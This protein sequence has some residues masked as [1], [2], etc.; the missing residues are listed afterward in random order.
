MSEA[1]A[2]KGPD[3][4][5]GVALSS[6]VDGVPLAGHVGD[7]PVLLLR[8]GD[9]V[10]A[11]GGSCTHYGGPLDEGLVVRGEE[12]RC[13]WHHACFS[14]R[15]G[16]VL[17]AP[18]LSPLARW[19]PETTGGVV[20][21]KERAP[22]GAAAPPGPSAEHPGS[23]VIIGAGA[24]GSAAAE[25]LRKEGYGG[26]VVLID[27][28][29][30]A[31]YDRPNLSKDYLAGSA[32]EEWL[33]LRPPGFFAE[34]EIERVFATAAAIDAE[35]RRV[36]LGDGREV[37]YG[38]LLLATGASPIMLPLPGATLPHVHVLRS[39]DDCRRLIAGVATARQAVIAGASFIG[40]EAAAALRARGVEVTVVA[41]EAVPFARTL[42]EQL[43]GMLQG[44]HEAAGV[45]FRLGRTVS[46]IGPRE[47]TID[48]GSV[49]PADLVLLGVGVRPRLELAASAGVAGARGVP[50]NEYLETSA[51]GIW[52]A[53]DI[54][55]YPEP[56]TGAA[57]RVE[58]WVAAQRQGQAAARNILGA[59]APFRVVP[60][61]WT[62]QYGV[63]VNYVGHAREWDQVEIEGD[64]AAGDCRVTYLAGGAMLAV[65]T[66]GRD[67]E[68]LQA[69]LEMESA[70]APHTNH[71]RGHLHAG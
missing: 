57:I 55:E 11:V 54:A 12:V 52:A 28:E 17:A 30:E 64:V 25:Q 49:L 71:G 4:R 1:A 65:A 23:V 44:L 6:L 62:Q 38:A 33:P 53:G 27:A 45:A 18:A 10:F 3:F 63:R 70:A 47:V 56:R 35:R 46:A 22:D 68:S 51:A 36:R 14:L 67:L 61:F 26:R 31:P 69:E 8:R 66:I 7:E 41:P 43:G 5:E 19:Q 29:R 40:L 48:D 16:E 42:G 50:V 60:F 9:D 34:Q 58:H 13:P 37:E 24:A 2:G 32:P 59:H 20:H 15:T 21:V 39:L